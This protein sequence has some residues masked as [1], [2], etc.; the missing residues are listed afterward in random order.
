MSIK[1]S[2]LFLSIFMQIENL[3]DNKQFL[4]VD[5][6]VQ[7]ANAQKNEKT[8]ECAKIQ[9]LYQDQF[10]TEKKSPKKTLN[11]FLLFQALWK[12]VA[13]MKLLDFRLK[14]NLADSNSHE[15][16]RK[17]LD[18]VLSRSGFSRVFTEKSGAFFRGLLF[19]DAFIKI[20]AGTARNPICFETCSINDV[21]IDPQASELRS[22]G[23]SL[24]ADEIAFS[25]LYSIDEFHQLFPEAKKVLLGRVPFAGRE[26]SDDK[27]DF[28]ELVH[29]FSKSKK[30]Y[31][32]LAGS[33]AICLK[34]ACGDNYPFW[35]KNSNPYL[36]LL[37]FVCF[38]S[39]KGFYNA[40]L[41]NLLY[42]LHIEA[43]KLMNMAIS[44]ISNRVD[45]LYT[46]TMKKS[47][48]AEFQNWVYKALEA[49][50]RG[51]MGIIP[52][53]ADD[54]GQLE[55]GKIKSIIGEQLTSE[56]ERLFEK[57]DQ[58][59]KRIGINLDDLSVSNNDTA[60]HALLREEN[61]NAFV[62]QI[63]EQNAE[64][65]RFAIECVLTSIRDFVA[66]DDQTLV[67]EGVTLGMVSK[68]ISENEFSIE[69][70]SRSGVYPSYTAELARL[71]E[72]LK[73]LPTGS[74]AH[75]KAIIKRSQIL[76]LPLEEGD[77]EIK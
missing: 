67:A 51:E 59:V 24:D 27:D 56:F 15:A 30:Q 4:L 76:G 11:G 48:I 47:K 14:S 39:L 33:N 71:D 69:I 34:K 44:A 36:P 20:G 35:D 37:H 17:G 57:Y 21:W 54:N 68:L 62:R 58:I 77:L 49:K 22:E 18:F 43:R 50:S 29:Y 64:E 32:V 31:F 38:S 16:V 52:V 40:G 75:K 63:M 13:K 46:I 10:L 74:L 23:G 1:I 72:M 9:V 19:G 70:D 5:N 53:E 42:N 12:T 3:S 25:Y 26:S 8:A 73:V 45:P 28:V 41:G 65:I 60:R 66:H 55:Y 61:S 2:F 6:L 7:R